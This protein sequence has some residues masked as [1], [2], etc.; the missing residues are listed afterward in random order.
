MQFVN[1]KDFYKGTHAK[2]MKKDKWFNMNVKNKRQ[3]T[4]YDISKAWATNKLKLTMIK[5]SK[6]VFGSSFLEREQVP[7]FLLTFISVLWLKEA[8]MV[9]KNVKPKELKEIWE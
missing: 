2:D 9:K 4:K 5:V 8:E 1:E 3:F 6:L 7:Q